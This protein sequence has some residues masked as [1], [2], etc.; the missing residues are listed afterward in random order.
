MGFGY[1]FNSSNTG[2]FSYPFAMGFDYKFNSSNTGLFSYPKS[3]N[4]S[5]GVNLLQWCENRSR[6]ILL[7]GLATSLT[8]V[9]LV[10]S[11]IQ[12][13]LMTLSVLT[14]FRATP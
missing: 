5:F 8:V 6:R 4:D 9:T 11:L 2:L 3:P 13:V 14:F 1:K 12:R 7:W 10:Y